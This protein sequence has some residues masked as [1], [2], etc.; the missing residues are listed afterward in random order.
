[1]DSAGL[2]GQAVGPIASVSVCVKRPAE[3]DA[4]ALHDQAQDSKIPFEALLLEKRDVLAAAAANTAARPCPK[5]NARPS[6]RPPL[7]LGTC[8]FAT[9][10]WKCSVKRRRR[11]DPDATLHPESK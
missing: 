5:S 4:E 3:V 10:L 2:G 1:M 6:R 9:T 7:K 8:G 11:R